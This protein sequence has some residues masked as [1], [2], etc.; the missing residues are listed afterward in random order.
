MVWHEPK[1]TRTR[2]R[3]VRKIIDSKVPLGSGSCHSHKC[4]SA[5]LGCFLKWWYPKIIHGLIGV[6]IINHPVWGVSHNFRKPPLQVVIDQIW[7]SEIIIGST[8]V[9][10][11]AWSQW[12]NGGDSSP[13]DMHLGGQH[14]WIQTWTWTAC[15]PN[16]QNLKRKINWTKPPWLSCS[17]C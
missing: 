12:P 16:Y 15:S 13:L 4:F 14:Q 10:S 3:E 8:S 6:S 17:T 5:W 7:H 11:V 9:D 1:T 2:E